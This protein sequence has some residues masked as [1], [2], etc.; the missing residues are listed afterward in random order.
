[1]KLS[2]ADKKSVDSL[3]FPMSPYHFT[4]M[5]KLTVTSSL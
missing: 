2:P 3:S 5:A 4:G 1:M